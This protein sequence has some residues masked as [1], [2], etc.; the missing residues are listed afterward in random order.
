[1]KSA[2]TEITQLETGG[3]ALDGSVKITT[4]LHDLES[5]LHQ[6]WNL[7]S[8]DC[9]LEASIQENQELKWKKFINSFYL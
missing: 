2:S 3:Y 5:L 7:N 9:P 6:F 8:D 4:S 1:M